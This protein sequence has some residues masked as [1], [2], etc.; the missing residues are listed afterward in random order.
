MVQLQSNNLFVES[1]SV[2]IAQIQ[3]DFHVSNGKDSSLNVC[4]KSEITRNYKLRKK[5]G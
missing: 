4:L 2:A 1:L 5:V 3:F